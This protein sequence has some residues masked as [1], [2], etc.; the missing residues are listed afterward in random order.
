[1]AELKLKFKENLNFSMKEPTI[2]S[3]E[4]YVLFLTDSDILRDQFFLEFLNKHKFQI[5]VATTN[6][7]NLS[8]K[9][10]NTRFLYIDLENK[11]KVDKLISLVRPEY[12]I[13]KK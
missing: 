6:E 2:K 1:M 11:E 10:E 4:K 5:I 13:Y 12:I 8:Q 3:N 7:R 9:I